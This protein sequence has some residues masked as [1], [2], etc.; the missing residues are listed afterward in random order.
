MTMEHRCSER[1]PTD[2]KI[3]IYRYDVPVA[4]GRIKNGTR[5]GL[6]IESDLASVKSL[7][8]L[9]IELAVTNGSKK[10]Q[11]YRFPCM[12]IH[13]TSHGFGL[14]LD[15][16]TKEAGDQLAEL[17]RASPEP[18]QESELFAMAANA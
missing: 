17:L 15:T 2:I 16:L 4:I 12:V 9:G 18:P 8:Q 13:T 7:Q 5:H 3:M 10:L 1:Y 6:F 11:T 14:E